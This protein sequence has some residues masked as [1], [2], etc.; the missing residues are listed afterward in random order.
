MAPSNMLGKGRTIDKQKFQEAAAGLIYIFCDI[1]K[2]PRVRIVFHRGS[3]LIKQ[4]PDG[5][6]KSGQGWRIFPE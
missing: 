5:N 4:F 6:V 3:E 2:F 1:T